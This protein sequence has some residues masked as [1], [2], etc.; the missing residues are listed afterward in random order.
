MNSIQELGREF[1][2][3]RAAQQ[4][5][6]HDDI[7]R[8]ERP[9]NWIPRWSKS[10]VDQYQHDLTNFYS[11]LNEIHVGES[12]SPQVE[13][14][15]WVDYQLLASALNRVHYELNV[16]SA[17]K[18]Q[19][20]FYVDQ[21]IGVVFD[22]LTVPNVDSERVEEIINL[23]NHTELILSN[24]RENLT[25]ECVKQYA[26]VAISDLSSIEEQINDLVLA[27]SKLVDPEISEKLR[28]SAHTASLSFVQFRTWLTE[29]LRNMPS[30]APIGQSEYNWFLSNVALY[31]FSS[32]E[33]LNI[34]NIEW[35]RAVTFERIAKNR[36]KNV[37]MRQIPKTASEQARNQ[38]AAELEIRSFY[39]KQSLLSQPASLKHYL[40]APMPN[41]LEPLR[42]LGVTDDFTGPSRL[43]QNSYSYVPAPS[44]SMPYFYAANASDTRAGIVHE[45]AHYQQ[46]ALSWKHD[47]EIRQ[48]YYDSGVNE[49]IA[50]Y[51]EEL[52]LAAGLFE[53]APNTQIVMWNF[54]KLR[55]LRVIV[56][57]NLAI[58]RMSIESAAKFLE[59]KVPMD[60]QTAREEA[61]MFS[62]SPGQAISYQIGKTQILNLISE[63]IVSQ[64]D[65][66]KLQEFH[67][68]L[69]LNGNVPISLLKF[70]LL[71]EN[72]DLKKINL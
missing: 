40:N 24:G 13:I 34:G 29:N 3:W 37:P 41:Y 70:E 22:L 16:I 7:P 39:E 51:N 11:Q 28:S 36:F 20:R 9:K 27:L 49:G 18:R 42:W 54:M 14:E 10:D 48:H 57:V 2:L 58:G 33:I 31:P 65:N 52:M 69:W 55:A 12:D 1:W 43:D 6:T 23:F 71:G 44:P 60:F 19:P 63:A 17:W 30:L 61:I 59:E 50:F 15:D 66:F 62:S 68:Y 8:I 26:E 38:A 64:G 56:D 45:G 5:R 53:D 32:N 35:D 67:D 4:P 47:R 72:A 46:L 25:K 21:T